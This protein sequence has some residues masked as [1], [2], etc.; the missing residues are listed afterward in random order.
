LVKDQ[1]LHHLSMVTLLHSSSG[2]M[3][4][5]NYSNVKYFIYK[6]KSSVLM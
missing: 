6:R 5:F 2:G 4:A 3:I 1:E